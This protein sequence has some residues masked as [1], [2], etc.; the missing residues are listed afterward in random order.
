MDYDSVFG[1]NQFSPDITL[2]DALDLGGGDTDALARHATASLLNSSS[3][4]DFDYSSSQVI[5][6]YQD[7]MDGNLDVE[8]TKNWFASANETGCPF[9]HDDDWRLNW[10]EAVN[11]E[12]NPDCDADAVSDGAND[13]D[14]SGP[15]VSGP[16]NC[17]TSPNSNQLDWDNDTL[18]DI[19][20]D[21]DGDGFVDSTE[22]HV[23]TG[24]SVQCGVGGWPADLY[25]EGLSYNKLTVQDIIS[26]IGPVRHVDTSPGDIG[27]NVRWDL[28]PG[29]TV[30]LKQV[31]IQDMVELITVRPPMFGGALAYNASC[32]NP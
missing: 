27:Y 4:M 7:A 16:D 17:L 2:L 3:D 25:A 24:P 20:D 13:T 31:N 12:Y 5:E 26:F 29:T 1:R 15:I 18:G 30:L 22:W 11:C 14:G 10:Y 21:G 32:P 23:G 8:A 19:C 28:L 6:L 9:D